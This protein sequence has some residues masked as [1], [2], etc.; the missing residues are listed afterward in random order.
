M[1]IW[2]LLS[3]MMATTWNDHNSRCTSKAVCSSL[4]LPIGSAPMIYIM[5]SMTSLVSRFVPITLYIPWGANCVHDKK[6]VAP[7]HISTQVQIQTPPIASPLRELIIMQEFPLELIHAVVEN[8]SSP[9]DLLHLRC[10]NRT[11]R[12]LVTPIVF[13]KLRLKSSIQSAQYFQQLIGTAALA[14]H[15]REVVYDS[16]DDVLFRFPLG[17]VGKPIS[18]S[19]MRRQ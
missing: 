19:S 9:T 7:C 14:S 3:S 4:R 10:V 8:V 18:S 11:Y 5:I 15:V 6:V 17:N 13:S 1:N 2:V 16:R 12:E